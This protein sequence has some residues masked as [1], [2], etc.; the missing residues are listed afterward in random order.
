MAEIPNA[1]VKRLLIEGSHGCRISAS[2]TDLAAEHLSN[3]VH[4]LGDKAGQYA[5]ADKRKTIMDQ[6]INQAWMDLT[7]TV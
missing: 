6:D 2:A 3:I 5:I 1:P 7:K 4:L